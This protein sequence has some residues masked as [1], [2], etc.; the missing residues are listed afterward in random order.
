VS[1]H[2][3]PADGVAG[4]GGADTVD[5]LAQLSFTV[6]GLLEKSVA[7]YGASMPMARL[8]GILRDRTPTMN[9][10]ATLL[11][12]DKSSVTGLVTRA[13]KRGLVERTPSPDD[14]RAVHVTLTD[15]GRV[16]VTRVAA[17]F[18]AGVTELLGPLVADDRATLTRLAQVVLRAHVGALAVSDADVSMPGGREPR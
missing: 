4:R 18:G 6:H 1:A 8:L 2:L 9:Q 5:A 7:Q 13:E 14:R 11:E 16:L 15:A 17:E 12:L 10:L 3:D